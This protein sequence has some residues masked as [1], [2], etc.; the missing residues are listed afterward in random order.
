MNDLVVSAVG[1]FVRFVDVRHSYR[2]LGV[3]RR[4]GIF[5]HQ[6]HPDR[7]VVGRVKV[8]HPAEVETNGEAEE[9]RVEGAGG[10]DIIDREIGC[11]PC[12][13]T[14]IEPR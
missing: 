3:D 4:G 7:L 5:R 14:R 9:I 12:Y 6:L 2:Y 13:G 8:H 1:Q 11:D 10:V